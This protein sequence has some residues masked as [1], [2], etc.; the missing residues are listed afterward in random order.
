MERNAA[1]DRCIDFLVRMMEKYSNEVVFPEEIPEIHQINAN[2]T[3]RKESRGEEDAP[4]PIHRCRE[5][6][7]A[8]FE[9]CVYIIARSVKNITCSC[10]S[11]YFLIQSYQKQR[12][13]EKQ[14]IS[15]VRLTGTYINV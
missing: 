5:W 12:K 2:E 15:S 13:R 1:F 3:G 6:I 8:V 9:K 14:C 10:E 4:A 11:G 7:K